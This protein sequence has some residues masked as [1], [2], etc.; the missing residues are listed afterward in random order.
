MTYEA[1][2]EPNRSDAF[3]AKFDT[4]GNMIWVKR[5]GGLG[6][7]EAL[8]VTTDALGNVFVLGLYSDTVDFDPGPNSTTHY[9]LRDNHFLVKL[10]SDGNFIWVNVEAGI[11]SGGRS[12]ATDSSNDVLLSVRAPVGPTNISN[13]EN[14]F[15]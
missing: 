5:I 8:D 12:I 2:V 6:H 4:T 14:I 1:Y 7:D 15:F 3:I 13:I 11:K 9:S 10:D